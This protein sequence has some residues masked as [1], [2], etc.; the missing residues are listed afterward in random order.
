MIAKATIPKPSLVL[1]RHLTESPER[2]YRA[3]SDPAELQQWWGPNVADRN[4]RVDADVRVGGNYHV[5]TDMANGQRVNFNGEYREVETNR[6]LSF[7]WNVDRCGVPSNGNSQGS[8]VTAKVMPEGSGTELTLLHE[9]IN[10]E[11]EREACRHGW[12]G[13]LNKLERFVQHD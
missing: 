1:K 2:V 13:A 3:W 7:T 5:V 4:V 8:R 6:K 10:N 11:V 9:D 12:L